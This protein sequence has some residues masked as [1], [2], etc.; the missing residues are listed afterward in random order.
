MLNRIQ[1]TLSIEEYYLNK[2]SSSTKQSSRIEIVEIID[3]LDN[4]NE[5]NSFD[6]T[7][8]EIVVDMIILKENN[9]N[10]ESADK[11]I[12]ETEDLTHIE[13][14]HILSLMIEENKQ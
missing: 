8:E 4:E 3:E 14:S 12:D 6:D 13:E 11:I 5:L 10:Y 7:T 1:K 9:Q 2:D